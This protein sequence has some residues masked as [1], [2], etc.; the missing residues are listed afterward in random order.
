MD[1]TLGDSNFSL[2]NVYAPNIGNE[3]ISFFENL[4]EAVS[5]CCQDRI[6]VLGGDFNCTLDRA[7]DRNHEEAHSCSAEALR[8]FI[9]YHSL[10]DLWRDSFPGVGNIPGSNRIRM[11]CQ[12]KD[13]IGFM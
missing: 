3:R 9:N 2:F 11:K 7:V 12:Q 13:L 5:E 8:S 4:S 6:I 1:I 10:T